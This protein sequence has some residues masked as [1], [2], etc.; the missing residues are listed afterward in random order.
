LHGDSFTLTSVTVAKPGK[1]KNGRNVIRLVNKDC[2][3]NDDLFTI[4]VGPTQEDIDRWMKDI[5][6]AT[7]SLPGHQHALRSAKEAAAGQLRHSTRQQEQQFKE[8]IDNV[9]LARICTLSEKLLKHA[10]HQLQNVEPKTDENEKQV[11]LQ[12]H[13]KPFRHDDSQFEN[14]IRSL[15]FVHKD[16]V[17]EQEEDESGK[18]LK[19]LCQFL[20]K[21]SVT[22]GRHDLALKTGE[23]MRRTTK[24]VVFVTMS[25]WSVLCAVYVVL[26][27]FCHGQEATLEWMQLVLSQILVSALLMRPLSIMA[28]K[29]VLPMVCIETGLSLPP[30]ADAEEQKKSQVQEDLGQ[31]MEE[32]VVIEMVSTKTKVSPKR[33]VEIGPIG[34]SGALISKRIQCYTESNGATTSVT[35]LE[36]ELD[37]KL[38]NGAKATAYVVESTV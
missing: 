5:A 34:L 31:K 14:Q 11:R 4:P 21:F 3:G 25:L 35:V 29:A 1:D 30:L 7:D 23:V 32:E 24:M 10:E 18:R 22:K 15:M 17:L 26:F 12:L 9:A 27:G 19:G 36:V 38:A 16:L 13:D 28:L 37:W 20:F 8:E 6:T 2:D 33:V